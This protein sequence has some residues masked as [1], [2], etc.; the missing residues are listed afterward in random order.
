MIN[1][2]RNNG[3]KLNLSYFIDE[4][5]V[6]VSE[7]S[8]AQFVRTQPGLVDY[9]LAARVTMEC[10]SENLESAARFHRIRIDEFEQATLFHI[11]ALKTAARLFPKHECLK[12]ELNKL[13]RELK[14]HYLQNY[15]DVAVKMGG[16]ILVLDNF[17]VSL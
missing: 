10:C 14:Q 2:L 13:F 5:F 6:K 11:F 17:S 9:D 3:H 8:L 4:S 1:T 15:D 7:Q 16:L 12:P